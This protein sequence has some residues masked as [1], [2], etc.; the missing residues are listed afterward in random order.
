[1]SDL[2][3]NKA[4]STVTRRTNDSDRLVRYRHWAVTP[5][6]GPPRISV[7]IPAYNEEIRILPTIG[8]IATH[9]S[10]LGEP[11]ELIVSDD[12]SRDSTRALV[13]DLGLVNGRVIEAPANGG[14][15]SAVRRGVQAARGE[16]ILFADADQATPIEQF[17]LL[18]EPLRTG[19]ADLAIGSRSRSG[20]A[21]AGKSW[22]RRALSAGLR[23]LVRLGF[24]LPYEDTQC[25]FK[26]FTRSAAERLFDVQQIEGFSFDLELLFVADR[27]GLRVHEVP[28][29]WF[30]SPGSTVDGGRDS[31]RFLRDLARIRLY[32][33]RGR[34]RDPVGPPT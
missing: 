14:K 28:V 9:M 30:D 26:L 29:R 1:M 17:E 27:A 13:T 24:G 10:S 23:H 21:V 31:I 34:Y 11:W 25:G 22:K 6:D 5:L 12:G 15:G 2:A 3:T 20:A 4:S 33:A 7:V 19:Q 16:Y 32:A 8:A 18:F